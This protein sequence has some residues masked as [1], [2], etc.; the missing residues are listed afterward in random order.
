MTYD[1]TYVSY[2]D[3]Y[4]DSKATGSFLPLLLGVMAVAV[5]QTI[6]YSSIH[7]AYHSRSPND[8][9]NAGVIVIQTVHGGN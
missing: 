2:T 4:L 5:T 7:T 1:L 8:E 3:V 6:S 9:Y